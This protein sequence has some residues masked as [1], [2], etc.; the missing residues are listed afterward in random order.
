MVGDERVG[1]GD[2]RECPAL[3]RYSWS[4][5]PLWSMCAVE[6]ATR[7]SANEH[8]QAS[9]GDLSEVGRPWLS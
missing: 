9:N 2:G 3:R 6:R 7:R 8:A 5:Y 4:C 1:G